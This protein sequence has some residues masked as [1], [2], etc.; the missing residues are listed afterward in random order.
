[1]KLVRIQLDHN[2]TENLFPRL[3]KL[4]SSKI[5]LSV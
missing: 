4:M 3:F 1:M 2:R 5:D